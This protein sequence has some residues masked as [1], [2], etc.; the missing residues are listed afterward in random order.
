MT[1][2]P[3]AFAFKKGSDDLVAK[4]NEILAALVADG[5]V[6]ELFAQYEAPYTSPL[7]EE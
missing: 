6:A 5:T 1:T 4:I 3:Y 7:T 2:E